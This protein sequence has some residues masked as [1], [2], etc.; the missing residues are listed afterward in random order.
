[1]LRMI[2]RRALIG[3]G[4]VLIGSQALARTTR[5][6]FEYDDD[7]WLFGP[8]G[9][10]PQH[11]QSYAEPGLYD[12]WYIGTIPDQPFPIPVVDP[13]RIDP[14]WRPQ[15]VRY[16]G[17]EL[18]TML[19]IKPAERFLYLI[20][21]NRTARRY[22][23]GVGRQGFQ[24]SGT[25][26]VKRKEKWPAWRP[27]KTMLERRPD[28]PEFME[29]GLEN[30]LGARALYLHQGGRDTLYRIHGTN[31]PNT[32][33]KA[34]SS[35]CIRLLNEDVY[36]LYNRVPVGTVVKVYPAGPRRPPRANDEADSGEEAQ[37]TY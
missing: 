21:P 29:G 6:R 24:W 15:T 8:P 20:Q 3:L 2:T 37:P 17:P 30:P 22:G 28:L 31:E 11:G 32:I 16:S 26:Y 35:G 18:P 19:V 1:M 5:P 25:A 36:D 10:A 9:A 23:I 27:P 13:E 34:V 7:E 14:R 12:E 33:G 4:T